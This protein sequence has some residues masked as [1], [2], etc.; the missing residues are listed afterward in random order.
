[1]GT[2]FCLLT[3]PQEGARRNIPPR[4]KPAPLLPPMGS[5]LKRTGL[6]W[7]RRRSQKQWVK[8][9]P[10]HLVASSSGGERWP[11]ETT[12]NKTHEYIDH[13]E[14]RPVKRLI[15]CDRQVFKGG[16]CEEFAVFV[17]RFISQKCLLQTAFSHFFS[18]TTGE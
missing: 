13:I 3:Q 5:P 16:R 1:M 15:A 4:G 8:P 6:T 18:D 10:P 9:L 12:R 2:S 11:M 17:F 7:T 14:E